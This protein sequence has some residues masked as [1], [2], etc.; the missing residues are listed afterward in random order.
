MTK[1]TKKAGSAKA[2]DMPNFGKLT[3]QQAVSLKSLLYLMPHLKSVISINGRGEITI[4]GNLIVTD[5]ELVALPEKLRIKGS[6]LIKH[7]GLKALPMD[8]VIEGDLVWPQCGSTY[9]YVIPVGVKIGGNLHVDNGTCLPEGYTVQGD[10]IIDRPTHPLPKNLTVKGSLDLSTK[11]ARDKSEKFNLPAGL[12]VWGNLSVGGRNLRH[13]PDDLT[14][15]GDLNAY[16]TAISELPGTIK[17]HGGLDI[18]YNEIFIF[19]KNFK[20]INGSLDISDTNIRD[21]PEGIHVKGDLYA[22]STPITHLPKKMKVDGSLIMDESHLKQYPQGAAIGKD[23]DIDNTQVK[24]IPEGTHVEGRLSVCGCPVEWLPGQLKAKRIGVSE[25]QITSIPATIN[26]EELDASNTNIQEVP[27]IEGLTYLDLSGCE[28]VKRLPSGLHLRFLDV[29]NT[30]IDSLPDDI[31]VS[32][33]LDIRKSKVSLYDLTE[34]KL[35]NIPAKITVDRN[36]AISHPGTYAFRE[37]KHKVR[38]KTEVGSG[39]NNYF[40]IDA[41][42]P[43]A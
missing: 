37:T 19:P 38:S 3:Q 6:V 34:E 27:S 12:S 17:I 36:Q 41:L 32:E 5:K 21:M 35:N 13:I 40:I 15:F 9:D 29:S 1:V 42:K 43:E 11:Y 28:K 7:T 16:E 25:T 4:D 39:L 26:V 2:L 18:S 10:L 24:L 33:H 31:A 20:T 8:L 23:V 14:V 22:S 30:K